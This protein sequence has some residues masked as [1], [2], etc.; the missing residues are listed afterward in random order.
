MF[1][2]QS[3]GPIGM[4]FTAA[5]ANVVMKVWDQCWI[6]FMI[7]EGMKWDMFVRYVDDCRL[8]LPAFNKGWMWNGAQFVYSKEKE[9]E[10]IKRN[11]PDHQRTTML[12]T[13]AMSALV[14]FLNFTGEDSR[15]WNLTYP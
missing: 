3:G 8:T 6:E 15:R 11:V 14:S 2:Q 9:E 7:R 12:V 1:L 10:D 5:L 4:R 13:E